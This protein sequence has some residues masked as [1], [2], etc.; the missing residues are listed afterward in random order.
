MTRLQLRLGS[1]LLTHLGSFG[2]VVVARDERGGPIAIKVARTYEDRPYVTVRSEL[3]R[4][5]VLQQ[6][7]SNRDPYHFAKAWGFGDLF[8]SIPEIAWT[9]ELVGQPYFVQEYLQGTTLADAISAGIVFSFEEGKRLALNLVQAVIAME[10]EGFAHNDIAPSNVMMCYDN[11]IVLIDLGC[12]SRFV[13]SAPIIGHGGYESPMRIPGT[14]PRA[15]DSLFSIAMCVRDACFPDYLPN[16]ALAN[17]RAYAVQS[18]SSLPDCA[19][20]GWIARCIL[21]R[22][23]TCE[24]AYEGLR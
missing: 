17:R 12:A 22:F 4:E 18:I 16:D 3:Y 11:R 9:A 24:E 21:G 23:K 19:L 20:S 13:A 15:A 8:P 6:R 5:F 7:L 10:S 1:K 2:W 14:S